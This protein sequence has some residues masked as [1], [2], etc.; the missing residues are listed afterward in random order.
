M[1]RLKLGI[2]AVQVSGRLLVDCIAVG[3]LAPTPWRPQDG[4]QNSGIV[5]G[6]PGLK[7]GSAVRPQAPK[8]NGSGRISIK[9]GRIFKQYN[10]III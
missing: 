6:C 1:F 4:R 3:E 9:K 10:T 2:R 7:L 8:E 5:T